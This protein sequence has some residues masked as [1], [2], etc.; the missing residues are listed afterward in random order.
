MVNKKYLMLIVVFVLISFVLGS[1]SADCSDYPDTLFCDDFEYVVNRDTPGARDIFIS[2][3]GWNHVKTY[4]DGQTGAKGY[5]YTVDSI[6]GYSG[7]FP[8]GDSNRVLAIEALPETFNY[9][10]DFYLQYGN[11]ENPAYDDFLPGDVWFQ[12]WVYINK[13]GEQDSGF[14]HG[15]FIYPCRE[16]YPC[17]DLNWLFILN[18]N[19]KVPD[20]QEFDQSTGNVFMVLNGE[21]ADYLPEPDYN[22]WKLGQQDTAEYLT[23]NRWQLVKLHTDTSTSSGVYEAWIR[24]I[25]QDWVKISEW[26]NGVTP[27]FEWIIPENAIGGHRGFRMP[28]THGNF[29]EGRVNYDSW[30]YMD[31][32]VIASSEDALP[33]YGSITPECNDGNDNDNDGQ[34]DMADS[35]CSSTLDNDESNCPDSVCEGGETCSSCP[36]DCPTQAGE[37]CCSGVIYTGDCCDNNYCNTSEQC[38]NHVCTLATQ[39]CSQL[40]GVDCCTGSETCGGT[41][42]SGSSD[43]SGIC[44]S[45]VCTQR[46]SGVLVDSTYPGYNIDVIDDE[47]IDPYGGTSTT[48]ASVESSTD[49]HWVVINFTQPRDI[50]NVDIYWAFNAYMQAFMS[51]QEIQVQYWDGSNY[52]TTSTITNSGSTQSSTT[53]FS[54]V[55]TTSLRFYQPADMG[56]VGY[57]NILWLTEIDYFSGS[58]CGDS[59]SDSDGVVNINELIN[60]IGEWKIG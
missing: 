58:L 59:D 11:T 41:S 5:L 24:P 46:G 31:D 8:G 49:P 57:T 38:V 6:P 40:G 32:F 19:S 30:F 53:T 33:V 56:P 15:K 52:I 28:T 43:C 48:W 34:I 60:Y 26:I 14:T 47:I 36:G 25:G 10:T 37:V 20:W 50:S 1:V 42:Y 39:T 21:T 7:S 9:Q 27:D 55:T 54:Q 45:Q 35:G 12:F 4:Q 18:S 2:Q 29:V 17:N 16:A 13:Y 23:P 44:C 3:G 51:S 22:Q